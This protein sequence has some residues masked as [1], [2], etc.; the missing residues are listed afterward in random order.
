MSSTL[1]TLPAVISGGCHC[2]N[3]HYSLHW[4][5]A[6]AP[7]LRACGCDYCTRHG[8]LWT[9]HPEAE[10][11]LC[12]DNEA[13]VLPYRFGT[14]SADFLV[15][16]RCGILTLTRCEFE[17]ALRTVVNANTFDNLALTQCARINT[18]F[19]AEDLEQRLARRRRNW[20]PLTVVAP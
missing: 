7:T 1:L 20:S 8:A 18:D 10:V 16:R 6:E 3:L 4:P 14:A 2:G 11:R 17:D 9:S 12:I 5:L 19:E 13:A 15:C